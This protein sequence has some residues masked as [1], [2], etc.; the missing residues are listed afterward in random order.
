M[1]VEHIHENGHTHHRLIAK[2]EFLWWCRKADA[3]DDAI[4]RRDNKPLFQW[5]HTRRVSEKVAAPKRQ[6]QADPEQG[7]NEPS[8]NDRYHSED[9]NKLVPFGVNGNHALADGIDDRHR[10]LP[11]FPAYAAQL[12]NLCQTE[13]IAPKGAYRQ[14][15]IKARFEDSF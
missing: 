2:P 7:G 1:N 14:G 11:F 9:C 15:A 13:A 8:Q 4:S 5:R 10:V 6:E 3:G 12:A